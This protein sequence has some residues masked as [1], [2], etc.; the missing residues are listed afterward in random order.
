LEYAISNPQQTSFNKAKILAAARES[1]RLSQTDVDNKVEGGYRTFTFETENGKLHKHA[2]G[3]AK[4][5]DR[6]KVIMDCISDRLPSGITKEAVLAAI[7]K[8][9]KGSGKNE[10][11]PIVVDIKKATALSVDKP[12]NF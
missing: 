6:V 7:D 3:D 5:A 12:L 4:F 2:T 11:M 9:P 1:A 8:A 10:P